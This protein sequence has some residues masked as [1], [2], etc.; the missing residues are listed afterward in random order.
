LLQFL[1]VKNKILP[2]T[3]EVFEFHGKRRPINN[4]NEESIARLNDE[5]IGKVNE[6]AGLYL[7][8]WGYEV[9]QGDRDSK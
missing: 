1:P 5:D 8:K 4:M 7:K 3:I 6:I 9:I 2:K